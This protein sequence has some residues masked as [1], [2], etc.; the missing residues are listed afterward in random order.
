VKTI[1]GQL[2]AKTMDFDTAMKTH[3]EDPG[4]GPSARPYAI[5]HDDMNF[6]SDFRMLSIRL[7]VDEVGVAESQFGFHIIKR[8]Q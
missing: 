3:S 5:A 4:S 6:D 7:H 2:T 8:I 1:V